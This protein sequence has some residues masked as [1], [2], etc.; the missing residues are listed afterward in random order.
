MQDGK[1][2]ADCKKRLQ[3][4][5]DKG[6]SVPKLAETVGISRHTI[7]RWLEGSQSMKLDTFDKINV[8]I[9]GEPEDVDDGDQDTRI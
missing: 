8:I 6:N 3:E 2:E 7:Y 4:Y 5:L 1:I 9:E